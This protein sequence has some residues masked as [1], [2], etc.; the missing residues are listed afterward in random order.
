[1]REWPLPVHLMHLDENRLCLSLTYPDW[2]NPFAI[3]L[4]KNYDVGIR[5]AIQT[6][7]HHLDFDKCHALKIIQGSTADRSSRIRT[8]AVGGSSHTHGNDEALYS[9][10]A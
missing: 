5:S 7:P 3:L 1:M 8:I 4:T 6:E 9:R 2:K 10:C